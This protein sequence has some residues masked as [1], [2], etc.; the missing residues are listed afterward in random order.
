MED[1]NSWFGMNGRSTVLMTVCS[2]EVTS[3]PCLFHQNY[4]YTYFQ[5]NLWYCWKEPPTWISILHFLQLSLDQ[6]SCPLPDQGSF[7]YLLP[8]LSTSP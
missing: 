6:H 3:L 5:N 2:T 7:F 1:V 8:P 4:C